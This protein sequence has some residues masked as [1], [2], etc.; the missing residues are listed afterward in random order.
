M[1]DYKEIDSVLLPWAEAKGYQLQTRDRDEE[2]RGFTIWSPDHQ[3]KAQVGITGGK[4]D[5]IEVSVF[6]GGKRRQRL[7]SFSAN[8]ANTLDE[9]ERL[10]KHWMKS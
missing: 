8:L 4:P 3:Q 7:T 5:E 6:D 1:M 2:V 9:A 10:A